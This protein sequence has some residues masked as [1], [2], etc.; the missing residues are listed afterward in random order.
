[1]LSKDSDWARDEEELNRILGLLAA[2]VRV[3]ER[4]R[5]YYRRLSE[6]IGDREGKII[7]ASLADDEMRHR[8]WLAHQ[9]D[10]IFPGKDPASIEPDRRYAD[11]VSQ[12]IFP[13]L[14]PGAC[15]APKDEVKAVEAAIEVEKASVR[16]Y[17]EVAGI[18][19]DT[20]LKDMMH[21]LAEWEKGHQKLL[22]ENLHYLKRGGS[23]YGYTP[24]LDG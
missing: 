19:A 13:D 11:I 3:E 7:L 16:M 10:R 18:T 15:L 12:R 6:C 8:S 24:I 2:A 1:M 4:G 23:W 22:E 21:R 14:A 5:D 17:L 20:E 9:I